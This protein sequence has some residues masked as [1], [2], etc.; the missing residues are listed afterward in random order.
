MLF[1]SCDSVKE[2][3]VLIATPRCL[4][5]ENCVVVC[6]AE[7]FDFS[8]FNRVVVVGNP[9]CEGYLA[10]LQKESNAI[11]TLG[12]CSAKKIAVSKDTLRKVYKEIVNVTRRTPKLAS[13]HKTYIAVCSGYK[14]KESTFMLALRIFD[15]LGTVK[16]NEKGF[17]QISA[18]SVNLEDSIAYR[19]TQHA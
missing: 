9:L 2:L 13:P 3:P 19:N 8:F 12:D 16:I 10:K 14:V 15:E 4:N 5:P 6:P 17:A 18:K 7:C 11:F 1:R